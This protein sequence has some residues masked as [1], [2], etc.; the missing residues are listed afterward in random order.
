M[1]AAVAVVVGLARGVNGGVRIV[2]APNVI[3]CCSC[4]DFGFEGNVMNMAA[5]LSGSG[6]DAA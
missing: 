3:I 1:V 2:S 5:G 6:A 4:G